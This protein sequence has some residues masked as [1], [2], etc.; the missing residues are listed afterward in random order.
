MALPFSLLPARNSVSLAIRWGPNPA[1]VRIAA[2]ELAHPILTVLLCV[3]AA[4]CMD[5][6]APRWGR[7][8][9]WAVGM[10]AAGAV[11]VWALLALLRSGTTVVPRL[12]DSIIIESACVSLAA[13][14]LGLLLGLASRWHKGLLGRTLMIAAICD[15]AI[16]FIYWVVQ[17]YLL[18]HRANSFHVFTALLRIGRAC[19]LR[20]GFPMGLIISLALA[21][22]LAASR[23]RHGVPAPAR[24]ARAP[25]RRR[26]GLR[27]LIGAFAAS[28]FAGVCG[29]VTLIGRTWM[30]DS[31]F[32]GDGQ[33]TT[34][35]LDAGV[36]PNAFVPDK[37]D[38]PLH[39]A[40]KWGH[41]SVVSLLLA[42]GAAPDVQD[43]LA[44][45]TPL[46]L[47]AFW[48]RLPAARV[49]LES[50]A[51]PNTTDRFDGATPLHEAAER[52]NVAMVRLLLEHGADPDVSD[53]EKLNY[54]DQSSPTAN[55]PLHRAAYLGQASVVEALAEAG[56]DVTARN[57]AQHT[58]LHSVRYGQRVETAAIL[59]RHG[60]DV[61]E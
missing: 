59:L 26:L 50:G 15:V 31:M 30:L 10:G 17:D 9:R 37:H 40:A 57:S 47:A 41:D 48:S 36:D 61:E 4:I 32:L 52:G 22:Q 49:L 16:F 58:P 2:L 56:A 44:E 29:G 60:A 45:R 51:D 12:L 34:W 21:S 7:P 25:G 13:A 27:C 1:Y 39:D 5:R 20:S 55:T 14:A 24:P 11:P 19:S 23:R 6:I 43:R 54:R 38:L 53:R 8:A 46:H 42:H 28:V 18:D 33:R 35:L 3:L